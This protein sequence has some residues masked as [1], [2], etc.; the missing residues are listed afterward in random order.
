MRYNPISRRKFLVGSGGI[1]LSIP[2]LPSLLPKAYAA[3]TAGKRF[4]CIAQDNGRFAPHWYPTDQQAAGL[5]AVAGAEYMREMPMRNIAGNLSQVFGTQFNGAIRDKLMIL[6]GLDGLWKNLQ[7]HQMST[8]LAGN[9]GSGSLTGNPE[10]ETKYGPS[11]DYIMAKNTKSNPNAA[12]PNSYVNLGVA[13][14]PWDLSYKY[15]R[16]ANTMSGVGREYNPLNAFNTLFKNVSTSPSPTPAPS[17]RNQKVVDLVYENYQRVV[18]S[19]KLARSEKLLLQEHMDTVNELESAII[20]SQPPPVMTAEC[21]VPATPGGTANR[22]SGIDLDRVNQQNI[23]IMVAAAKCG[24]VNIGTIMTTYAVDNSIYDNLGLAKRYHDDYSHTAMDIPEVLKITQYHAG[25]F[26]TFINAL[27]VE[28][29]GTN[30]TY[31][32]NSFVYYGNAMGH[33]TGHSYTDMAVITA[34]GL[35]GRIKTGRYID[36]SNRARPQYPECFEGRNYCAFLVTIRRAFGL[37]E[38]DYQQPNVAAGFGSDSLGGT[39]AA[40]R[41]NRRDPLPGLLA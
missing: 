18:S 26:G 28:E 27:N 41:L 5:T 9:L 13:S 15:D 33:G 1:L 40:W 11:I 22:S 23:R 2:V 39:Y 12:N 24:I 3:T 10:W 32:D 29:P 7:G 14:H 8:I 17:T 19:T 25:L 30:A 37:V 20:A 4:F 31:L 36:Y 38:A 34:G 6:R 35:G 16:N 21:T